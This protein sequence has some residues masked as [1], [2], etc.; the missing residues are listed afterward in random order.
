MLQVLEA[1]AEDPRL[2]EAE[3]P[4]ERIV[5]EEDVAAQIDHRA[6]VVDLIEDRFE[7][8][9]LA[10]RRLGARLGR[11]LPRRRDDVHRRA[12]AVDS[13]ARRRRETRGPSRGAP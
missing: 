1:A 11:R 5:D 13:R 4:A 12:F 6:A 2:L 8:L 10:E 7:A 9:V 3:H